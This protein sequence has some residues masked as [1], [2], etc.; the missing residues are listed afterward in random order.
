MTG[1][2]SVALGD[3]DP[4]KGYTG[5]LINPPGITSGDKGC[6][7][8]YGDIMW[9]SSSYEQ[10]NLVVN[11]DHPLTETADLHVD[12]NFTRGDGA[13]RYAPSIG[14]FR[15]RPNADLL[16]AIND[17]AGSDFVADDNDFF[18][19]AHRFV[20]HG[21]RD[22]LWDTGEFDASI[23]LEGLITENLGYDASISA[24]QLD[25]SLEGNT[26]V[27]E[28]RAA[29]E[30]FAGNYDLEN[31]FSEAPDHSQAIE[32]TSLRE[33]QEFGSDYLGARFALEG[34]GFAIGGRDAA[35]TAGVELG[36][37]KARDITVYRANDGEIYSVD[38]VLGSGGVSYSG[39]R[40]SAAA[41]AEM[42]LPVTGQLDLR[43]G[44]R[45]D[46]YDDIGGMKSWRLGAEYRPIDLI[47][48]RSS[49][50]A[51]QRSPSMVHLYSFESQDH[52]YVEC[53]PGTGS[54]P[55]SCSQINPRQVTRVTEGNDGLDPSDTDRLAIEAE[56]RSW[57]LV[58]GVE[59]YRLS[60][61]GQPGQNSADWAMQNLFECM[62][63]VRAN[64]IDRTG[65]DITIYDSYANVVDDE[66]AGVNVR[67]GWGFR[68]GWGTVGLRGAWRHVTDAELHIAGEED[69]LA[70]P[71]NAAR[72][73]IRAQRGGLSAT[74][75][76]NYRAGYENRTGS[77]EFESWVGHDVVVDWADPLGL[78]GA[79]LTAG[80]F[81]VT[82]EGLSV[83]TANPSSVDGP[84]EADWGRTFFITANMQF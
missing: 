17:A 40:N 8:A 16:Q 44:A 62:D 21:N 71:K 20:K 30:I 35:W 3:C 31:P 14:S 34:P 81:N 19:V 5:P 2:R 33:E 68:T 78:Q 61:S 65:G 36:T 55:R 67:F 56:V 18:V 42:S 10:K 39:K 63:G 76:V 83:N 84:T 58:L 11:L 74:W 49:W 73:G 70:I 64:C 41:F 52:P 75:T 38:D 48:L 32:R 7:F 45:G 26:F 24:F 53:D 51:G 59:W 37:A 12:A 43:A 72:V 82:D 9:N 1:V 27:H 4:A 28:G 13:F 25:G 77:G 15:F 57:P 60:R 80:I 46:E 66:L 29:S 79:R 47:R 54:P 69:R 50:S 23:A 6:G 22:W